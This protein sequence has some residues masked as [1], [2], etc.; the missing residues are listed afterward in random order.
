MKNIKG[1]RKRSEDTYQFTVSTGKASTKDYGRKYKTYTVTEKFTPKQLE[2]HL[3]HEY[4]KFKHEVQS[5]N[6]IAPQKMSFLHFIV[7]WE[8]KYAV[9]LA[10]TTYGNHQRK[11]KDHISPVIGHME[12]STINEFILMDLLDN[13]TRKDGKEGELSFHSKQDVYRT[14]KS[15]FKYAVR[16]KV[17]KENP[18]DGVDKPRTNDTEEDRDDLQVYDEEELAQLMQLVQ[19]EQPHWQLFFTLALV[20]GLRRGELLGLEWKDVDFVSNQIEINT[21][22]VL[23][24][25]GPH[26]KKTKTKSS[27][28]FVTLPNSMMEELKLYRKQ[29]VKDKLASGDKWI[30][31]E[32]EWIFCSMKGHH[33]HPSSPTNR[34]SKFINKHEFKYIRLHDLRHTSA[35]LLIAQGVHAKIISERLGHS[36]ISVTMNTY[37]HAFKSA[38]RDAADK[39]ESLFQPQVPL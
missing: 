2:E 27:K 37:G 10:K 1:V 29:W 25:D 20:A 21:S 19:S 3:K 13:L 4:L 33:L 5:A 26:I 6:Y 34:W 32:Y 16:W 18:M 39:L 31:E 22:I 11:L 8:S 7:E 36:D 9:K 15:V 23:T 14:L 35:S 38:D 17:L 28:R 30:E 12:M 24:K